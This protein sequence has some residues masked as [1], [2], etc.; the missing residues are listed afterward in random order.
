[1]KKNLILAAVALLLISGFFYLRNNP[2]ENTPAPEPVQQVVERKAVIEIALTSENTKKFD[3]EDFT[4]GTTALSMTE[5]VVT[6]QKKG[7]GE[8]AFVTAIDG[9]Q[10][11]ESKKEFWSFY[12]NGKQAEVGAGTY[13]VQNGD[14]VSWKIETY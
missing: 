4:D 5:A 8:Q 9:V 2:Q 11:Q 6:V 13:K 1:M 14:V 7:E 10:A 12:V 3:I